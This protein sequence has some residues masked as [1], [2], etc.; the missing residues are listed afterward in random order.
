MGEMHSIP[1]DSV[2]TGWRRRGANLVQR[3]R[4]VVG[5]A[6][7]PPGGAALTS[8][9][10]KPRPAEHFMFRR[11]TNPARQ[12]VP[13]C[14]PRAF[15]CVCACSFGSFSLPSFFFARWNLAPSREARR[16]PRTRQPNLA[17]LT[18]SAGACQGK[19]VH[20]A[21]S[22]GFSVLLRHKSGRKF[23]NARV[24]SENHQIP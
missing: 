20:P 2:S 8:A 22:D 17:Q 21:L 18:K 23:E 4:R 5:G 6:Q 12:R 3:T 15:H 11:G 16:V 9:R 7:T 10:C 13:R 24:F 1:P 19:L 14:K